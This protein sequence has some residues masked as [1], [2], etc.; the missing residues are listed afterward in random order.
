MGQREVVKIRKLLSVH[1]I[2]GYR[3]MLINES[4]KGQPHSTRIINIDFDTTKI[5]Q[6]TMQQILHDAGYVNFILCDLIPKDY[7]ARVTGCVSLCNA[8][9]RNY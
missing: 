3:V 2:T 7:N 8:S 9:L 4:P 1:N 6:T 5:D